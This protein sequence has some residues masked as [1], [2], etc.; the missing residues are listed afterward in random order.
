MGWFILAAIC[1]LLGVGGVAL[2]KYLKYQE[3]Y[4]W[5]LAF[6]ISAFAGLFFVGASLLS[7]FYTQD[8][9]QA[10]VLVSFSGV[11]EGISYDAGL[12]TKA[13]WTSR[14]EYDIRNNT[15]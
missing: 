7:I 6:L 15:L 1:V 4:E 3:V 8:P 11:V 12:H 13:P 10:S 14:V 5:K 2:A 9:G